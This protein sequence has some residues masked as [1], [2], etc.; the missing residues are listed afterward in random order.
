MRHKI[1]VEIQVRTCAEGGEP[2]KVVDPPY[3][4]AYKAAFS[5]AIGEG[6]WLGLPDAHMH[7]DFV[8]SEVV[9][10]DDPFARIRFHFMYEYFLE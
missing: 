8:K 4:D 2:L 5:Q 6:Q 1:Q 3:A 9:H 7:I 10:V